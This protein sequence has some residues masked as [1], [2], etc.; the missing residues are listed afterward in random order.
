MAKKEF[1]Q[2]FELWVA[3]YYK[4]KV[5]SCKDRGIEWNL[6]LISVRNLL[7]AKVCGYT[8][9]PL[10]TPK[11]G[12]KASIQSDVTIDRIDNSRPYEKGNVIAVS[13][14]ANNFKSLF[15]NPV[16]KLDMLTAQKA[17]VKMQKK[18]KQVK[19]KV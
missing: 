4:A 19:E 10:T 6:N 11:V 5:E 16:Y 2:D 12:A 8:G 15:E 9:M 18:L 1:S 14:V 17:L 13:N 3:N 7:S